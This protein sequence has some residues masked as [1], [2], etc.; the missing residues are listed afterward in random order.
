M[1]EAL[2]LSADLWMIFA[3]CTAAGTVIAIAYDFF[4]L[5]FDDANRTIFYTAAPATWGTQGFVYFRAYLALHDH[6][7]ALEA[8]PAHATGVIV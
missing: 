7:A 1:K 5:P 6:R 4:P 8:K 2:F 3:G